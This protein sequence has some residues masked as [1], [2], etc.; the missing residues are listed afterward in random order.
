MSKKTYLIF[1]LA[2]GLTNAVSGQNFPHLEGEKLTGEMIVLPQG[3]GD[4]VSLI[5]MAYSKKSEATLKTWYQ[6]LYNKFVLKRGIWDRNYD[7]NL[8]FVPMFTG[9]KKMAYASSI[10]KMKESNRQDLYPHLIFY[11][12]ELK[13]Y[14]TLLGMEDKALPYLFLVDQE[15]KILF[16]T[17]G[18]YS[19]KKME[20]IEEIL[21]ALR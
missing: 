11:K 1:L 4:K 5:G 16:S 3:V 17:K 10:S 6:P 19:D 12:G 18:L 14:L 9:A 2:L 8:L 20:R 15:G 13:P 7:V 21:D